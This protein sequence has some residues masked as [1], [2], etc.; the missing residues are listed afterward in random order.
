M[1]A[2]AV[3]PSPLDGPIWTHR[4][5][6][7]VFAGLLLSPFVLWLS[8][9]SLFT[10]SSLPHLYCLNSAGL[11]WTHVI[12]DALIG[13]AYFVI[14]AALAYLVLKSHQDIPFHS[15]FLAFGLFI[16]ACGET[17]FLE[18]VTI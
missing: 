2:P 6:W 13:V 5:L 15:M 9:R 8:V 12:A 18:V 16:V 4:R 7:V 1:S 11:L 3:S 10:A 17:H 14:S